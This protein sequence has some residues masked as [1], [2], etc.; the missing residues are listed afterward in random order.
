M[1]S[2]LLRVSV[3]VVSGM[4]AA[5]VV[6]G[7]VRDESTPTPALI[8][9]LPASPTIVLPSPTSL[10]KPEIAIVAAT[11]AAT[12]SPTP[13]VVSAAATPSATARP[14]ATTTFTATATSKQTAPGSTSEGDVTPTT[15]HVPTNT[16]TSTSTATSSATPTATNL[17][18]TTATFTATPTATATRAATPKPTD[19][20]SP[21]PNPLD[22]IRFED[23]EDCGDGISRALLPTMN[24]TIAQGDSP[25]VVVVEV[26]D[27]GRERQQ[28]LMCRETVPYG[29]GM[30]FV[31]ESAYSL[32][33]WMFNTYEPLDIVYLDESRNVVRAV[34]MEPC[35]RP[36]G[37][38]DNA[39]R[40]HCSA[41]ASP[42]G[43]G[44][45]AQYALELPAGW[46]ASVGFEL[47]NLEGVL[48]S[49]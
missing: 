44:S 1:T 3:V 21:P 6:A 17:P 20:P 36:D 46:L 48:F 39:W 37:A 49:W 45:A 24:L 11:P 15:T 40:S 23:N 25:H 28:G 12:A 32:N 19:T 41:A 26:A 9:T 30:L 47:G 7:C 5:A 43:S 33:F 16:A 18:E 4:V 42:Y 29:S 8:P 31:F 38:E 14:I 27:D 34:R 2:A 10:P 13:T 35:P 22:E